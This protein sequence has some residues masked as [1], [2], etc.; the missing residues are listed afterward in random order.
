MYVFYKF[1]HTKDVILLKK[2]IK[3]G[4][5]AFARAAM[6]VERKRAP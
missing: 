4:A 1:R 2:T 6:L 3:G 5:M